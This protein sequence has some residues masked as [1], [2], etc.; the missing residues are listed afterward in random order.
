[1]VKSLLLISLF[2]SLQSCSCF[3]RL[4]YN[5]LTLEQKKVYNDIRPEVEHRFKMEFIRDI[6]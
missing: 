3:D 4:E 6:K 5:N 2:F 1:M